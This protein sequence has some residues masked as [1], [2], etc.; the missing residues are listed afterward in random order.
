VLQHR[1]GPNPH[2]EVRL[3]M[4][5]RKN[6]A[7]KAVQ[8]QP[9]NFTET[10][11][12]RAFNNVLDGARILFEKSKSGDSKAYDTLRKIADTVIQ[13][14]GDLEMAKGSE[15]R[16]KGPA[17]WHGRVPGDAAGM[18]CEQLEDAYNDIVTAVDAMWDRAKDCGD[19]VAANSLAELAERSIGIAVSLLPCEES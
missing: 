4:R 7:P 18:T 3:Q 16:K 5:T 12:I 15:Y 10:D 2:M 6:V 9:P 11:I 17:L 13:K 14:V 1:A 8:T 19:S